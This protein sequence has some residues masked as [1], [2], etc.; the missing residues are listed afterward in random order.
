MKN[1]FKIS[2][3]VLFLGIGLQSCNDYLDINQ[4]P[5]QATVADATPELILPAAQTE[6]AR[7]LTVSMNQLG[8]VIIPNWANNIEEFI[9][10]ENETKY[11]FNSNFYSDIWEQLYFNNSNYRLVE[12]TAT[13]SAHDHYVAIAKIMKSFNYQYLVDLYGD[14]PYT[15]ALMR[16]ENL[17]PVYDNDSDVYPMLIAEIDAALVLIANTNATNPGAS[18]IMLGGDM[19]MWEKFANT[20]KL[21]ILLRQT[22]QTNAANVAAAEAQIVALA[23]G[24]FLGAGEDVFANPGYTNGANNRQNPF[25]GTYGSDI[26]GTPQSRNVAACEYTV[27]YLAATNDL[28][29][30]RI[31]STNDA[32]LYVGLAQDA[33]DDPS[34]IISVSGVGPGLLTDSTQGSKIMTAAESLL[35]QAEAAQEVAGFGGSAQALYESGIEE[36]FR[37]LGLTQAQAQTYYNQAGMAN[38]NWAASTDKLEAIITQKWTALNGINGIETWIEHTRTGFPLNLPIAA[39]AAGGGDRPIRLLYPSSEVQGNSQ[40]VPAQATT[41]VF[42]SKV[43]WNE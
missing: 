21:R 27:D 15:E 2:S 38:V 8:N 19:A 3:L 14:L 42:T 30:T 34:G 36:S 11:T 32:G 25:F 24:P 13:S 37:I 18:D 26:S 41:D 6:G 5:N 10:F 20:L 43:F 16:D 39:G 17:T 31:Y 1:I 28:R 40:N 29:R 4:D 12:L 35:L 23:A 33:P 22:K 9:S 7:R